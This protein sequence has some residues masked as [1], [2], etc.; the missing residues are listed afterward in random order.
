MD[1][2]V[3]TDCPVA[4]TIWTAH[5]VTWDDFMLA[6]TEYNLRLPAVLSGRQRPCVL[7][8]YLLCGLKALFV[9]C[10]R[11]ESV[12]LLT[13][14]GTPVFGSPVR[15]A[16]RLVTPA[17]SFASSLRANLHLLPTLCSLCLRIMQDQYTSLHAEYALSLSLSSSTLS[18][19]VSV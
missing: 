3:G 4:E 6:M 18:F 15:F 14:S 10:H 13:G 1:P 8:Y 2:A 11:A 9:D 12:M 7:Y 16:N 19:P 17:P 5:E